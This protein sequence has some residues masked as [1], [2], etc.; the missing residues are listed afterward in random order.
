MELKHRSKVV[1]EG[2]ERAAHRAYLRDLGLSDEEMSKPFIGIINS[3]GEFHPG[4]IVLRSFAE[5]VK[6]GVLAAGGIP[7]EC[8]TIALCD[9]LCMG[10]SGMKWVLPSRE[11]IADSVEILAE[12]NRFDALVLMA[13]CDKIV[14]GMLMG[15]AR[16]DIPTI[17]FTGGAM[18][19]GYIPSENKQ[20]LSTH[21]REYLGKFRRGEISQE[22]FLEVECAAAPTFGSCAGMATAN[23]MSC[24]A[25]V[26]GMSLPGCGTAP[27]VDAKKRSLAVSTGKQIIEVLR[28][29]LTPSRIMTKDA[30]ENAIAAIA[31]LGA[32]TNCILHLLAIAEE[33]GHQLSLKDFDRISQRTPHVTNVWPSGKYFVVDLER[34]G[35]VPAV[36]KEIEP[37]LHTN[38][39]TITG[40]TL[41]ENINN[42]K[43]YHRD[44]IASRDNPL[45]RQGGI[46]ILYGN[47]APEGAVIKQS[48]VPEEMMI[49][50]GPAKVYES[51]EEAMEA[52]LDNQVLPGDVVVIRYEGPKGGPGMREMLMPTATLMGLG[53][54]SSVALVTDGRFS[55]ATRGPCVGHVSP[56]AADGGLIALVADGDFISINIPQRRL[57]LKVSEEELRERYR[58]WSGPKLKE[59]RGFLKL[60]AEKASPAHQG[61]RLKR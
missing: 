50:E 20:I 41:G 54:G 24:L 56:E 17:M 57:E 25:E 53:L 48:A 47:L 35:G 39:I 46:A 19:P 58:K 32:S 5:E 28:S 14:P 40:K 30:L 33:L 55:G 11:L 44:V 7:F 26:L 59:S 36:L 15:A 8:N 52:I 51:E 16:V 9:G 27:A 10:H 31:A 1:V 60:Y 42:A 6:K 3:W 34:A 18:L 12:G 45:R 21:A 4:H 22:E 37:F 38:T 43:V 2:D 61:A 49:H 29:G 13:A 23:S